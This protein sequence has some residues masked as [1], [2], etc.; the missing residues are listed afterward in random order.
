MKVWANKGEKIVR[1]KIG[2]QQENLSGLLYTWL[3]YSDNSVGD[4]GLYIKNTGFLLKS[5]DGNG[6]NRSDNNAQANRNES[7]TEVTWT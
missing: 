3:V 6:V 4:T 5:V 7:R 1:I 2:N